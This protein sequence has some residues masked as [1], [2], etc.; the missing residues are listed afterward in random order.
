M[1]D[2]S[3]P[4]LSDCSFAAAKE[5]HG[6]DAMTP[7]RWLSDVANGKIEANKHA[8]VDSTRAFFE[9]MAMTVSTFPQHI[10]AKLKMQICNLVVDTEYGLTI[11]TSL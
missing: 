8:A 9:S 3:R 2:V 10:Q 4:Q 11:P 5:C 6:N 7:S 1:T